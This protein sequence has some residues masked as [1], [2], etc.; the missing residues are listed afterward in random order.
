MDANFHLILNTD[1]YFINNIL[2]FN[3][4]NKYMYLEGV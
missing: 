1:L 4:W 2:M 3:V